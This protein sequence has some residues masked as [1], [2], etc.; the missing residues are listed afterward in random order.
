M[1]TND[2][3]SISATG[4]ATVKRRPSFLI[5][6]V[7]ILA[8]VGGMVWF[9]T[10]KP[11]ESPLG[12]APGVAATVPVQ[13]RNAAAEP[14]LPAPTEVAAPNS[15]TTTQPDSPTGSVVSAAVAATSAVQGVVQQPLGNL[16]ATLS[17]GFTSLTGRVDRLETVTAKPDE[18]IAALRTDVDTLRQG[19]PRTAASSPLSAA[20]GRTGELVITPRPRAATVHPTQAPIPVATVARPAAEAQLLAVDLWGGKPSVVVS[21][22]TGT[23]SDVRFLGEGE[24]QGSVTVRAADVAAQSATFD[25]AGGAVTITRQER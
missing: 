19:A 4:S 22:T 10:R 21:R 7:L 2:T 6:L 5:P 9:A 13:P 16:A 8:I 3:S 11:T 25:T 1:S 12:A 15:V 14:T 17:A 20:P 18:Q 24:R 23:G